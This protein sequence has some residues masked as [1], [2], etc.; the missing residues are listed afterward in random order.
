LNA[1][2]WQPRNDAIAQSVAAINQSR[3]ALQELFGSGRIEQRRARAEAARDLGAAEQLQRAALDAIRRNDLAKAAG[4]QSRA[5]QRLRQAMEQSTALRDEASQRL[6]EQLQNLDNALHDLAGK[7]PLPPDQS[8]RLKELADLSTQAATA[9][10]LAASAMNLALATPAS[11]TP[12]SPGSGA[13]GA[14]ESPVPAGPGRT[15]VTG[16]LPASI[17]DLGISPDQWLKLS[18]AAQRDVLSTSQQLGPPAYRPLIQDYY[19]K[20]SQMPK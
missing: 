2:D 17:R 13:T 18:P 20:V 7:V 15:A 5:A 14:I 6:A 8:A 4:L 12:G 10:R 19:V 3:E 9:L 11:S 16:P 1:D